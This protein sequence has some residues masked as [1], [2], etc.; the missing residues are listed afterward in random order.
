[1]KRAF[2]I[3]AVTLE[4]IICI[5]LGGYV[6]TL[7]SADSDSKSESEIATEELEEKEI[8]EIDLFEEE[9]EVDEIPLENS[10]SENEFE[11][12]ISEPELESELEIPILESESE[13]E[14]ENENNFETEGRTHREI[15][16]ETLLQEVTMCKCIDDYE[17]G[18]WF[19]YYVYADGDCYVITLK[20]NVIDKCVQLN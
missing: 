3:L 10:E 17:D 11:N 13:N 14:S 8:S 6:V 18:N 1:M 7:V 9:T 2:T 20:N 5:M 19:A 15:I 16:E 12:P 4:I